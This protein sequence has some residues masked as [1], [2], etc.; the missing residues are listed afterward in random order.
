[1]LDELLAS[2]GVRED[3]T[4][5][6]RAGVLAIHGGLEEGTAEIART[7]AE[8]AGASVYIVEQPD[9]LRWHVPSHRFD[10]R[11]STH[12]A[13]FCAHVD[14]A[15]SLHGYG[16]EGYWT[17]LLLGGSNRELAGELGEALRVALPGYEAIT[18]LAAIPA[19]LRGLH[20]GNPV[21]RPRGGGVQLELPPRVRGLG[22]FWRDLAPHAPRSHTQSLVAALA[23]VAHAHAG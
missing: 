9:D 8:Q 18:D 3:C 13:E 20:A 21:N 6:S 1:V 22:P 17:R 16:R 7:A 15:I 10:P 5:R 11:H 19:E 12:L 2:P 14:V 23:E 4:L